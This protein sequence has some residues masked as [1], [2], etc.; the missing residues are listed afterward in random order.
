MKDFATVFRY[1]FKRQTCGKVYVIITLLLCGLSLASCFLLN[2]IFGESQKHTLFV[3]DR[4][5]YFSEALQTADET[6]FTSTALD[7]SEGNSL[8]DEEIAGRVKDSEES[9]AVFSEENGTIKLTIVDAGKVNASD[10]QMLRNLS[11]SVYLRSALVQAGVSPEQMQGMEREIAFESV[12]P[13]QKSEN[14]WTAYVLYML[15][16][17]AIVMYSSSS[18]SEVAYL[19]TNKVM[20]IVMTSIKSLPFYLG[21]T[22]SVGLSALL[23]LAAVI[24]C[25]WLSFKIAAPDLSQFTE[26]GVSLSGLD[27]S[28]TAVFLL[29]FIGGFLLYSFL[30]TAVASIVSRNDDLTATLVPIEMLAMVQFFVSIAALQADSTLSV[31]CSYI[32]FTS[33]AVM[34]VRY[35]MGYAKGGAFLISVVLLYGTA[36]LIAVCGSRFFSRGVVHY[37]RVGEFKLKR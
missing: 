1:Y 9:F 33:P 6:I 10:A 13:A 22:L 31:I 28:Q 12:N 34:F 16:V 3:I 19:K 35:M 15:M 14:F 21:V 18:G 26:M 32:P 8:S 27:V 36:A 4:T 30:I 7:F 23:Q 25:F 24:V 5:S 37:G 17:I 11:Q 2:A 20:E 29:M